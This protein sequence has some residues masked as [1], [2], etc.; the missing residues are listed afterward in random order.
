MARIVIGRIPSAAAYFRAP[1]RRRPARPPFRGRPARVRPPP[2]PR[3]AARQLAVPPRR[4]RLASDA[5]PR[6]GEAREPG[7]HEDISPS[8]INNALDSP[9]GRFPVNRLRTYVRTSLGVHPM[10]Q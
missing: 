7:R 9:R 10:V 2:G 8:Q 1:F 4:T 6:A 5:R 3:L